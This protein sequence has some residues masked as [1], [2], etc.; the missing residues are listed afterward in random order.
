MSEGNRAGLG[1]NDPRK[2]IFL[3]EFDLWSAGCFD[4]GPSWFGRGK[5]FHFASAEAL[6]AINI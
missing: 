6:P 4:L 1:Q 5:D 2:T 3:P